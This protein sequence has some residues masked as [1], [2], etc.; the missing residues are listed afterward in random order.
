MECIHCPK[1][2]GGD[3]AT[4]IGTV[5]VIFNL[6]VWGEKVYRIYRKWEV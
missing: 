3:I 4:V 6:I 5:L 2:A 1:R